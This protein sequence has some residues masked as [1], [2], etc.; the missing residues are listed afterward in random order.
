MSK[1]YTSNLNFK[2][3]KFPFLKGV[4]VSVSKSENDHFGMSDGFFFLWEKKLTIVFFG[5]NFTGDYR[6]VV[7]ISTLFPDHRQN[8]KKPY[9]LSF[10]RLFTVIPK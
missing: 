6:N 3:K 10:F 4:S 5:A 1:N 9:F 7:I 2:K 8:S